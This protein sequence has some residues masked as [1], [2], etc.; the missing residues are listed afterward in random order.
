MW[1]EF[2][3]IT[4]SDGQYR[5]TPTYVG[6]IFHRRYDPAIFEDHPHVCG[7]NPPS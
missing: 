6:R 7:E 5:I 4:V 3:F 1:G 2:E